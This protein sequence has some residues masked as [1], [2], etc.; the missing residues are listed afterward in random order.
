MTET[1]AETKPDWGVNFSHNG[2][3]F[4]TSSLSGEPQFNWRLIRWIAS[5]PAPQPPGEGEDFG[6]H[7]TWVMAKMLLAAKGG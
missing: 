2:Q 6:R 7:M 1:K 4:A 3:L 5:E